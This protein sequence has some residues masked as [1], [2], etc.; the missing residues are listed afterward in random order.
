MKTPSRQVDNVFAVVN[1]MTLARGLDLGLIAR[2][3]DQLMADGA[4]VPGFLEANFIQVAADT[5]V[6]V[7]I[8]ENPESVQ[9]VHDE[10]GLPWIRENLGPYLESADRKLGPVLASSRLS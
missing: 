10:I 7:V 3:Q 6:M 8:C 2:M 9:A 4:G 1:T 5:A